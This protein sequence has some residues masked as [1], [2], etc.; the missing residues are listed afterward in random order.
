MV[1][2]EFPLET[3]LP[4]STYIH[5]SDVFTKLWGRSWRIGF[6]IVIT[7]HKPRAFI[8][9]SILSNSPTYHSQIALHDTMPDQEC[10]EVNHLGLIVTIIINKRMYIFLGTRHVVCLVLNQIV[11]RT[12][13]C[14]KIDGS[15]HVTSPSA[16]RN[17]LTSE[18]GVKCEHYSAS[19]LRRT[20]TTWRRSREQ[21]EQQETHFVPVHGVA[22][23]SIFWFGQTGPGQI[24]SNTKL[25]L[26]EPIE[27]QQKGI[28]G[29][30]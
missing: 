29:R 20:M 22:R 2:K 18:S 1:D 21:G 7:I 27:A 13:A 10:S 24:K 26:A 15:W 6:T 28:T 3:L 30:C 12:H 4:P 17:I 14:C 8:P 23:W 11:L 9:F 16:P 5:S 25:L 19:N